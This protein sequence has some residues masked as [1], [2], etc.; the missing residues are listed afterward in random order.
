VS[1]CWRGVASGDGA[2]IVALPTR[3][4][5]SINAGQRAHP[6]STKHETMT[7][8]TRLDQRTISR[9]GITLRPWRLR[10]AA[11]LRYTRGD[12]E[13]MRFTTVPAIFTEDAATDWI[14][15]QRQ[16]AECGTAVVLAITRA[17]ERAPIGMV[18]LF[19]LDEE[20]ARR[21]WDIGSLVMPAV[22][23]LRPRRR[24]R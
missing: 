14:S 1:P 20:S 2:P 24:G 10:D 8:G 21:D 19:G 13:I 7:V 17:G 3:S 22:A 15:R 6:A 9:F 18:G 16:R 12:E 11:A 23:G 5:I 4:Q